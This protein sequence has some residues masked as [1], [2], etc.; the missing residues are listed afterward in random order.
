MNICV[1]LHESVWFILSFDAVVLPVYP[2]FILMSESDTLIRYTKPLIPAIWINVVF[3]CTYMLFVTLIVAQPWL[4]IAF[5]STG[6]S[7]SV[8]FDHHIAFW[9]YLLKVGSYL[10]SRPGARDV[11]SVFNDI[12][13]Y[14]LSFQRCSKIYT[15]IY[16]YVMVYMQSVMMYTCHLY[17]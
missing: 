4:G 7:Q 10:W 9:A 5:L 17:R 16:M 14:L 8:C 6:S 12:F 1:F 3:V 15:Y 11:T 2:C 13:H